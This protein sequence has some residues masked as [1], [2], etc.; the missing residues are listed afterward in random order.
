MG[1]RCT[2]TCDRQDFNSCHVR[3]NR[4]YFVAQQTSIFF[5]VLISRQYH[6]EYICF[7]KPINSS[8]RWIF[9]I[10]PSIF[11]TE[12]RLR[13]RVTHT[14]FSELSHLWFRQWLVV[15][16]APN[17]YLNQIWFFV[18]PTHRKNTNEFETKYQDFLITTRSMFQTLPGQAEQ[19]VLFQGP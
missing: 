11:L 15:C 5:Y 6:C 18:N 2:V 1:T 7:Y 13:G 14:C 10:Y 12:K 8:I 16:M 19:A 4:I 17:Q 3:F 9:F